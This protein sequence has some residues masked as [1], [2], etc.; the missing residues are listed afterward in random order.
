M[1]TNKNEQ[2]LQDTEKDLEKLQPDEGTLDLPEVKDIPGQENIHPPNLREMADTTIAS[3]DEEGV[4]IFDT[5]NERL[6]RG[7]AAE[8]EPSETSAPEEPNASTQADEMPEEAVEAL[9]QTGFEDDRNLRHARPDNKDNE[10]DPLNE[11]AENSGEDLD[12]P[13]E[14][15][16]DEDEE[17]GEEDEE[18]NAYSLS[19]DNE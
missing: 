9:E 5:D 7:N 10:G 3:D 18:N 1:N 4:G 13:G 14:E 6:E 8:E 19:N 16:D 11:T 15:L 17:S 2:D 12:I